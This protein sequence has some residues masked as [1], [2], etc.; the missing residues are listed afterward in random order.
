ML[1]GSKKSLSECETS[2]MFES[3]P[4]CGIVDSHKLQT[5]SQRIDFYPLSECVQIEVSVRNSQTL[6]K[7]LS[8]PGNIRVTGGEWR[9]T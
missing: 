8:S 1:D 5:G 2:W 4:K 3:G 7:T 9:T 6:V